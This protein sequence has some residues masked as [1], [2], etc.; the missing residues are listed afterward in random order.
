[1][2][3]TGRGES[4]WRDSH[5]RAAASGRPVAGGTV[6]KRLTQFAV[7][8]VLVLAAAQF[9]RPQHANPPID[10]DRTIGAQVGASGGSTTV[11]DRACGDC[12]SNRTAWPWYSQI[13]R[14]AWLVAYGVKRGRAA[15]SRD[16]R[17][18]PVGNLIYRRLNKTGQE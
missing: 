5:S 15:V 17:H 9:V 7:V 12:H 10:P 1:M 3:P 11:L 2:S 16:D 13:A 6:S 18:H 4:R 8:F 14:L